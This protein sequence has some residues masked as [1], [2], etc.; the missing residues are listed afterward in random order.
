MILAADAALR[1]AVAAVFLVFAAAAPRAAH[2]QG[3]ASPTITNMTGAFHGGP[4]TSLSVY[5]GNSQRVA[6]GT[7]NGHL[8]W[9]EDGGVTAHEAQVLVPRRFDPVTIRSGQRAQF[10][11]R[12]ETDLKDVE[13]TASENAAQRDQTE[14]RSILQFIYLLGLGL[15]AGR[16]QVWMQTSDAIPELGDVAWPKGDGPM[17]LAAQAGLMVSDRSRYSWSRTLGGP[18]YIPRE[19][20]LIGLS[21]A[22]DPQNPR[23]MLAATDRGMQVSDNSGYTW[24]PHP[25]S[26]FE[27]SWVTRIVWDPEN[28]Q[29]VFAV[30]PDTILLSQDGGLTF[31]PSFS[32]SGEIKDLSLSAEA[33]VVATSEGIQVATSEGINTL[34]ADKDL[35]G[36]VPWRDGTFLAATSDTL[37]L[38]TADGHPRQLLT[39]SPG[40]LYLRLAGD[41]NS[42]W[43]LSTYNILRI[44][45]PVGRARSR[46]KGRA[47]RMLMSAEEVER[48]MLERTGLGGPNETR[49]HIRWYAKILPR[50]RVRG[51]GRIGPEPAN[52]MSPYRWW[53]QRFFPVGTREFRD[54]IVLPGQI[55]QTNASTYDS[56]WFEVTA[57]WD[58]SELL[59]GDTHVSNP[60]LIIES[61]IRDKRD[62]VVQQIRWHYRE[63]AALVRDLAR[64]PADP[65]L[66]LNWRLRL[67]EHASYLEWMTNRKVVKRTPIEELEY[68]E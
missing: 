14:P 3:A 27:D 35:I 21:V 34:L 4:Y 19:G 59:G 54:E 52:L 56:N 55:W 65:E 22:I 37:Y 50:L 13:D 5:P 24:A 40:D 46:L 57:W 36:A 15:P 42:V 58:L 41:A 39:T 29:L 9:S 8:T 64:P 43:L 6:I 11:I 18:G 33:A 17:L 60:N 32:A 16:T 10:S 28:P 7:A 66:E 67:E 2:A 62:V 25:D 44:G 53:S 26:D 45:D 12:G 1:R 38:V 68:T 23:H 31:E 20:D 48:A 49:L 30:T 63:C 61:Q 47:P 51:G